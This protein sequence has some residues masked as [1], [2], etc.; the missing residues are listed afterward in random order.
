MPRH[1]IGL[2]GANLPSRVV[3]YRFENSLYQY[4]YYGPIFGSNM[5][6]AF[7][8]DA[9]LLPVELSSFTSTVNYSNIKLEW[10]TVNEQNNSG[11]DIERTIANENNWKKI[12]F[13]Q[14]SGTTNQ[15]KNYSYEDRNIT[16][17]KYQ[18]RLKQIDF[19]GN[20]EYHSL[21]NEVEIGVPKKFSLSQNYPN[22]FNPATKINF[23]IPQNS[24]V[25][26]SVYDVTGKLAIE[27]VNEQRAAGY[28][29]V[30]FNGSNLASGMYFYRIEAGD[31]SAT[32]KMLLIK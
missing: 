25:K 24:N 32:K 21:A 6:L 16:S 29:T 28:Y 2:Q 27:L 17:G 26:L 30:E 23:E 4:P 8:P 14:G 9:N 11:F 15:A 1:L 5:A 3:N 12:N 31:F 7:G 18:Y 22:P 10:S 20:Y 13:V 19:N